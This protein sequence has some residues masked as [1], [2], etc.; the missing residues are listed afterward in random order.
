MTALGSD[1]MYPQHD[2]DDCR[3]EIASNDM[4]RGMMFH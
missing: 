3:M 4:I 1:D 2:G